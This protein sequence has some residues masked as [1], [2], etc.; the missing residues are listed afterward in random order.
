MQKK[1]CLSKFELIFSR[2]FEIKNHAFVCKIEL[3]K[4]KLIL[5]QVY[6][7]KLILKLLADVE[8]TNEK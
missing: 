5:I 1:Y 8:I 6:A 4:L 2:H 3:F 7:I